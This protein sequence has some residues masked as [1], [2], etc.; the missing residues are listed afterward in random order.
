M[1]ANSEEYKDSD[2]STNKLNELKE[3]PPPCEIIKNNFNQSDSSIQTNSETKDNS[4]ER[5]N[6]LYKNYN[7]CKFTINSLFFSQLK[8]ISIFYS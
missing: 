1:S 7:K 2:L 5:G 6:N 3:A 4:H 8:V